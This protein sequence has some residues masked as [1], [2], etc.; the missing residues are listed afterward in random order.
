MST[1]QV[2]EA[3]RI[4]G[5]LGGLKGGKARWADKSLAERAAYGRMMAQAKKS[6][7]L[8]KQS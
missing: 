6:K 5:R 2:K 1:N 3:A 8:P 4:I 7:R